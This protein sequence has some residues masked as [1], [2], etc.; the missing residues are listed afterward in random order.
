MKDAVVPDPQQQE[1]TGSG[2]LPK[3]IC[4]RVM[5]DE[6]L[7][8]LPEGTATEVLEISLHV[9]PDQLSEHLQRAID[10]ADGIYDP[11]YLGYGLCSKAV[12]G[13]VAR[14]SR[15]VIPKTDD[16]IELFLGSRKARL[17]QLAG[18]P[19]T[20]FLTQGYIGDGASM[21]FSEHERAVARYGKERAERLI[22][23][24]MSHYKRLVYIRTAHATSLESDREY[25]RAMAARFLLNYEELDG[26]SEWLGQ[27]I[28]GKWDDRFVVV[29]PG[30]KIELRHF[31]EL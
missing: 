24:M 27:L 4:C 22:Q 31:T 17:D 13:L 19:G 3:L 10:A 7:P 8:F 14:N 25:A 15:L 16:C 2:R 12:V 28:A 9:H 21:I 23:S 5:I 26:T 20:F 1:R 6:L 11:I 30:E 29:G 18:E